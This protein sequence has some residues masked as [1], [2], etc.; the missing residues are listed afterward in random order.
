MAERMSRAQIAHL[1]VDDRIKVNT[2]HYREGRRT[3]IRKITQIHP[4]MG[5][6]IHMFGYPD[7]WLREG[8]IIEK[9]NN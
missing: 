3:I 2:F 4:D 1:K 7:F 5:I 8:E 9:L 6:A